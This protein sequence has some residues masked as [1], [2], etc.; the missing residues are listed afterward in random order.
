MP[1]IKTLVEKKR[2]CGFRKNGGLYLMGSTDFTVYCCKLPFP[3][4]TCRCCGQG[5]KFTPGFSWISADLFNV[6]SCS[7]HSNDS[8]LRFTDRDA[9]S[10]NLIDMYLHSTQLGLMWVGESFY[11]TP[12]HFTREAGQIGISKRIA[13]IPLEAKPGKTWIALA[14]RKAIARPNFED[15][16]KSIYLPGIFMLFKLQSIQYVVNGRETVEELERLEKRGVELVNVIPEGKQ[17]TINI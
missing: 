3:L 11:E 15:L 9:K 16:T 10:C 13:R 12:A 6:T 4:T 17:T 8:N 5:I 14:H 2:G 1:T 7:S